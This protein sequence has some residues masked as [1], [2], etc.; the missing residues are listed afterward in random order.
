MNWPKP[1]YTMRWLFLETTLVGIAL[2]CLVYLLRTQWL[3]RPEHF[4]LPYFAGFF[5]AGSAL[6]GLGGRPVVGGVVGL[7]VSFAVFSLFLLP[8][9]EG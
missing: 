8:G 1:Q 3:D 6:G 9:I 2:G 4:F 7:M 5:A